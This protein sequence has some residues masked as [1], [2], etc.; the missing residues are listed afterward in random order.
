MSMHQYF[1]Y[2]VTLIGC[3]LMFHTLACFFSSLFVL[4]FV[5]LTFHVL[6]LSVLKKSKTHKN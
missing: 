1:P 2:D 3:L 5:D 6:F 4:V